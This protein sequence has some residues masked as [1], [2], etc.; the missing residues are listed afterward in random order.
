M[1]KISTDGFISSESENVK[2]RTIAHYD[3]AFKFYRHLNR[4]GMSLLH[5]TKLDWDDHYRITINILILRIVENFQA[6]YLLLERGMVVPS[7]VITRA[8][9]ETLFILVALEKDPN[10]LQCYKDQHEEAQRRFLKGAQNFKGDHSKAS[11]KRTKMEKLYIEKVRDL[12]GKKL[13]ILKPKQWA[14]AADLLDFYNLYY[15]VYSNAI[16]SNPSSLDDHVESTPEQRDICFGPSEKGLFDLMECNF[17]VFINSFHATA[18]VNNMD[19]S[20]DIE[21]FSIEIATLISK[22]GEMIS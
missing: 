20:K 13:N 8:N 3:D 16:H 17:R 21:E 2:S 9:L 14:I 18:L 10:L 12:N 7:K 19:I 6:I 1:S 22:Y 15:S 4:Y 11:A 5:K